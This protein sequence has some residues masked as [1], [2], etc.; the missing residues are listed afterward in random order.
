MNHH[1][2]DWHSFLPQFDVIWETLTWI[3][4]SKNSQILECDKHVVWCLHQACIIL[5]TAA[6]TCLLDKSI[7]SFGSLAFN[8]NATK[9]QIYFNFQH[10]EAKYWTGMFEVLED[11]LTLPNE[12]VRYMCTPKQHMQ[13]AF[14]RSAP[15][16]PTL[17]KKDR[18][19]V[20]WDLECLKS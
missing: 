10:K 9:Q 3:K 14:L 8:R 12:E 16:S 11:H 1:V 5:W 19:T 13:I 4:V 18:N 20:T 2:H 15:S 7:K 17:N 6:T